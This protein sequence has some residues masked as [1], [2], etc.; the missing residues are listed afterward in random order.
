MS[1]T[2]WQVWSFTKLFAKII[3][4]R[5]SVGN[6]FMCCLII[7]TTVQQL[8]W[9]LLSSAENLWKQLG[10]RWGLTKHCFWSGSE[11][12]DTLIVF[13]K[14][15]FCCYNKIWNLH[16]TDHFTWIVT[17]HLIVRSPIIYEYWRLGLEAF[18]AHWQYIGTDNPQAAMNY[19][20]QSFYS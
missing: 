11:L 18:M 6:E 19:L 16:K 13:L 9:Q 15:R 17:Q 8:Q 3:S 1:Q 14:E 12:F 20:F 4:R 7:Q 2:F 5:H 10:H